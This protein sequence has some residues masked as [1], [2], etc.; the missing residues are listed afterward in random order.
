MTSPNANFVELT[1]TTLDRYSGKIADNVTNH[2]ALLRR[3]RSKGNTQAVP[4]G[5][6]ILQE[7]DYAENGTF[8]WYSGYETL[9]IS[10]SEVLTAAEFEWKLANVNVT[11]SG[12]EEMKNNGTRE[13]IHNLLKARIKNAERTAMNNVATALYANGTGNSGKEIGGLQ[14]LLADDPTTGIVGGI[15]RATSTN[16]WWRHQ[17]FDFSDE[18]VTS[19]EDTIQNSMNTLWRRCIRGADKPDLILADDTYYAYYETSLQ[20]NLRFASS[21]M[22]DAGFDSLKYKSADVV[23]DDQCPASH[24]YFLNTDY[25]HYRPHTRRNF[26][27]DR[28]RISLNQ[29]ATVVPMFW[30]GN[31]TLSNASVQGVMVE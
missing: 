31:M 12:E 30:M 4:G 25:I 1:V 18:S 14:H 15:N 29:D 19:G 22:A 5:V 23:Y 27:T 24:M 9:D 28:S 13:S 26:V 2:N 11:I 20:A 17:L 6:K 3:L 16:A 7:L 10:A 8:K 21:K